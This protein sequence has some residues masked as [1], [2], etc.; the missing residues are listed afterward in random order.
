MKILAYLLAAALISQS[1]L[2]PA[3]S[4]ELREFRGNYLVKARGI[5]VAEFRIAGRTDG[6][7]YAASA[8]VFTRGFASLLTDVRVRGRVRGWVTK[9]GLLPFQYFGEL[10]RSGTTKS[11]TV[12]YR[13]G[14]PVSVVSDPPSESELDLNSK[15]L[16][17][18]IDPLTMLFLS[19]MPSETVEICGK[20]YD[21][22]D[23]KRLLTISL[24]AGSSN[25][26]RV[27]CEGQY[28][29]KLGFTDK[30]MSFG[31]LG[32]KVSFLKD[33]EGDRLFRVQTIEAQTV[34]G[35]IRLERLSAGAS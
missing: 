23:G 33:A 15:K 30:E 3:F 18:G 2:T 19:L 27:N 20:D 1:A 5:T 29:L 28:Q 26:N 31:D 10:T 25:R 21:I 16:A 7:S 24:E 13:L 32:F 35:S 14:R 6:N 17:R 11:Q 34:V 9:N 12:K 22:F 4:E 8:V